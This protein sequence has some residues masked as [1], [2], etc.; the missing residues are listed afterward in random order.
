MFM[1]M[2]SHFEIS[3]GKKWNFSVGLSPAKNEI[4]KPN[5]EGSCSVVATDKLKTVRK[6]ANPSSTLGGAKQNPTQLRPRFAPEL[7][8]L[9]C[10]ESIVPS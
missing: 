3:Q 5:T 9:H 4:P 10:F 7:D 1:S 2:F 6:E 8:G